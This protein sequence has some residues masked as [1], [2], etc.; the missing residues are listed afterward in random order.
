IIVLDLIDMEERKNRQRVMTALQQE[1]AHDRAPSKILSINDFGLVAITRKRVKQSLERTLCSPCPYCTGAGMVK[2]AQTM[3]FEI[4]EQAKAISKQ[5]S[6]NNEVMLRVSPQVAE[7]F[8]SSERAVFEEVEAH[9]NS[10]I[11]LEPDPN[12]HQEQY[13]F[14]VM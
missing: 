11:T 12:L 8:R 7:A 13:D 10:P 14:A 2:S 6:G 1:L 3:C 9:F 4:L 5:V